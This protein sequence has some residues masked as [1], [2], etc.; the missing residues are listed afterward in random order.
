MKKFN[1]KAQTLNFLKNKLK[2]FKIPKI[3]FFSVFE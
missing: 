1:T 3:Y 2:K